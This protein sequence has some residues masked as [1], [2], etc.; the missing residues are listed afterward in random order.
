MEYESRGDKDRNL[1]L[2]D[3]LNIIRPFL[4]DMINNHKTYGEWKI[5]LIMRINFI[6][7]LD[8]GEFR[9]MHSKSNNVENMIGIET[10]DIIDQPFKSLSKRYQELETRM[11]G[12][13]FVFEN[14]DLL[15]YSFHRISLNRG[16]SN[17][18][19]PYWIKHKKATIKPKSKDNK[20][21]RDAKTIAL[22]HKKLKITQK[23]YLILSPFL[24]NVIGR[25]LSFHHTQKTKKFEQN[26]TTTA[27]NILFVPYNILFVPYNTKK[28]R[29]E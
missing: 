26:N 16:G 7:S 29:D 28:I 18:N 1:S 6:S 13:D 5:Q 19:S 24:I 12:S 11:E 9:I 21:S 15:Y 8:T 25:I 4:K 27:L 20:C 22:Y 14:V 2:E 23:V 10:D 17:I 3:Y